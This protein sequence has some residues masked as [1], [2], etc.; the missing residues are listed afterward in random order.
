MSDHVHDW[1]P[2]EGY[3]TFACG[4]GVEAH[5]DFMEEESK[6]RE[7]QFAR[8]QAR[9]AKRAERSTIRFNTSRVDGALF[10]FVGAQQWAD[11]VQAKADERFDRL[12]RLRA[13]RKRTRDRRR[14]R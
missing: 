11:L 7:A 9:A 1:T 3:S 6:R 12:Y 2:I 10:G 13:A 8:E 5:M 4:C 14:H